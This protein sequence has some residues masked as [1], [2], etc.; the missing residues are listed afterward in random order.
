ME[1][2]EL[3]MSTARRRLK[4]PQSPWSLSGTSAHPTMVRLVNIMVMNGYDNDNESNF[5]A[6]NYIDHIIGD[7]QASSWIR[8]GLV[9]VYIHLHSGIVSTLFSRISMYD[10][11]NKIIMHYSSPTMQ[12][13][14]HDKGG[15]KPG[16]MGPNICCNEA[17]HDSQKMTHILFV[18]CQ[19]A[20]PILR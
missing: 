8:N 11:K 4:S 20:V 9:F 7:V 15:K 6:M 5:I 18:P 3:D 12:F 13:L 14:I 17:E 2:T 19:S 10:T 1:H 16:L